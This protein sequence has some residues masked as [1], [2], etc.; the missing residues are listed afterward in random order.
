ME[1][2][3]QT[4]LEPQ[5]PSDIKEQARRAL[6]TFS[7]SEEAKTIL[8][9]PH[10][11]HRV[12]QPLYHGTG[13]VALLGSEILSDGIIA[14]G[15]LLPSTLDRPSVS[16]EATVTLACVSPD[17]PWLCFNLLPEFS[18]IYSMNIGNQGKDLLIDSNRIFSYVRELFGQF[19]S[20]RDRQH[21]IDWNE[22]R[23][24]YF[25]GKHV[26]KEINDAKRRLK[27]E[28]GNSDLVLRMQYYERLRDRFHALPPENQAILNHELALQYPVLLTM[29]SVGLPLQFN[30]RVK[31]PE[32]K[33]IEVQFHEPINTR[34]LR[35]IEVPLVHLP[36]V[37]STLTDHTMRGIEVRPLEIREYIRLQRLAD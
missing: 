14:R 9:W 21:V 6:D 37:V 3:R 2:F 22:G 11:E 17:K 33:E 36:S 32:L 4:S 7:M 13:S 10:A 35:C 19:P 24:Y 12:I 1:A 23:N 34:A 20:L 16:G 27:R 5:I 28:P 30:P 18:L 15:V 26:R 31:I 25:D 8:S 29:E